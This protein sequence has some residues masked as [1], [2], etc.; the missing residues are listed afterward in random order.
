M[1]VIVGDGE[2]KPEFESLANTLNLKKQVVFVGDISDEQLPSY[3]GACDVLVL[4]SKDMSEGFGLTL[5]EANATGKPCIAS[6]IGGIPS[7][8]ENNHNGILVPPNDPM[9]LAQAII[10]L[11]RDSERCL[12]FGRNGRK[13]ALLRDWREIACRTEQVYMHT[14]SAS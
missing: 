12:Q 3:Y 2:L 14:L 5:L 8:I 11:A 6:D 13:L 4:P 1:L 10:S 9:S 7:V